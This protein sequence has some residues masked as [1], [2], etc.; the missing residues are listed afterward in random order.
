[1]G[2]RRGRWRRVRRVRNQVRK[3]E[4]G[5]RERERRGCQLKV[6]SSSSSVLLILTVIMI[7]EGEAREI[8]RER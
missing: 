8:E 5:E 4:A 7:R 2:E 6:L 1:M 3:G